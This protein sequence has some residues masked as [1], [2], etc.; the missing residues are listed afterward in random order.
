M[1]NE[2][3]FLTLEEYFGGTIFR[4]KM[5]NWLPLFGNSQRW[6]N[7]LNPLVSLFSFD[8]K[9]VPKICILSPLALSFRALKKKIGG[10]SA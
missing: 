3:R 9:K 5:R 7:Y 2:V 6:G 1:P 8:N 10:H 4:P